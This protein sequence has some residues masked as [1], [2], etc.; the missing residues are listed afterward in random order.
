MP[1]PDLDKLSAVQKALQEALAGVFDKKIDVDTFMKIV[2]DAVTSDP[3]LATDLAG[4]A[5]GET[6]SRDAKMPDLAQ[7]GAVMQKINDPEASLDE[8]ELDVYAQFL[9][10]I[11][12]KVRETES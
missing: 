11:G 5:D 12:D 8:S 10:F 1:G 9:I 3:E 2:G 6:A 7:L 4:G